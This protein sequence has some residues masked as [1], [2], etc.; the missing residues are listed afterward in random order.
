MIKHLKII[1]ELP[2]QKGVFNSIDFDEGFIICEFFPGVNRMTMIGIVNIICDYCQGTPWYSGIK[3]DQY[4]EG[5]P[6]AAGKIIVLTQFK[7]DQGEYGLLD[8][9]NNYYYWLDCY[10]SWIYD[11]EYYG[12]Y[13][14]CYNPYEHIPTINC[15]LCVLVSGN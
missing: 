9:L 5:L 2:K 14:L 4:R 8:I 13:D 10:L 12:P 1:P 6:W 3:E 7:D 11:M 15:S